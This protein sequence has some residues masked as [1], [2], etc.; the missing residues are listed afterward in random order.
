MHAYISSLPLSIPRTSFSIP[1][2]SRWRAGAPLRGRKP[3]SCPLEG[4]RWH[5]ARYNPLSLREL[6][7][8][9]A[10]H[11][12]RLENSQQSLEGAREGEAGGRGGIKKGLGFPYFPREEAWDEWPQ[13]SPPW[14]TR[15][16]RPSEEA[17]LPPAPQPCSLCGVPFLQWLGQT[18]SR[19]C[20]QRRA[21]LVEVDGGPFLR[22]Q[23]QGVKPPAAKFLASALCYLPR[24]NPADPPSPPPHPPPP[25]APPP[26]SIW[27]K[28]ACCLC[29][30]TVAKRL[31]CLR[32]GSLGWLDEPEETKIDILILPCSPGL[33]PPACR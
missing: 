18:R 15:D 26:V 11:F 9:R 10:S 33:R 25:P 16:Q 32:A 2:L 4:A 6:A 14:K 12:A 29:I 13:L 8:W 19:L 31:N 1:G 7:A 22:S 3:H 30:L 17:R 21:V 27:K 24:P 20:P 23:G 5:S 28:E